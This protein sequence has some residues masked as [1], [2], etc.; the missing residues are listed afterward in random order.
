[1]AKKVTKEEAVEEQVVEVEV[2]RVLGDDEQSQEDTIEAAKREALAN[3]A[4]ET[5]EV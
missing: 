2:S 3:H 4:A 5:E 1:M